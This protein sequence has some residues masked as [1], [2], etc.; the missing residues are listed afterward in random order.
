MKG[1][2]TRNEDQNKRNKKKT[3]KL[4][5]A[6]VSNDWGLEGDELDGLEKKEVERTRF[7]QSD[8]S[9]ATI[10]TSQ[11]K[12]RVWSSLDLE[13]RKLKINCSEQA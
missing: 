8:T 2:K 11:T 3:R 1:S 10:G 5:H 12:I 4:K 6:V 7:L 9:W 13:A